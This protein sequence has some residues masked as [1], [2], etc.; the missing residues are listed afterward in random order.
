MRRIKQI[1]LFGILLGHIGCSGG[2]QV[3]VSMENNP[4]YDLKG[5]LDEQIAMLDSL[6]PE[7]KIQALIGN[8]QAEEVMRKDSAD[9]AESL[10]LYSEADLN[11]P[12][13]RDQYSVSDSTLSGDDLQLKIYQALKPEDVDIPYMKVYYENDISRVRRIETF[14]REDN[15]LYSTQRRMTLDF[16]NR[17]G[18]LRLLSFSTL[19]KQKMIFRDSIIYQTEATIRY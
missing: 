8:E 16:E 19:G 2:S 12:V 10:A 13:L 3:E 4:Y 14:F 1:F 17:S 7:V 9:W 11:K 18:D 6:N 15:P 5:L